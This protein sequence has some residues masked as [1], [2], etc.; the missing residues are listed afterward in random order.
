LAKSS[1]IVV[2]SLMDGSHW[3]WLSTH[4]LGT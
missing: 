2:I 3:W 4:H 1:P